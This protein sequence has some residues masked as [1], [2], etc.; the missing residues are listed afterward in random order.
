[1]RNS[2]IF[3]IY[4]YILMGMLLVFTGSCEKDVDEVKDPNPAVVSEI[5]KDVD[6]NEYHTVTIGSQVWMAENLKVTK[7]RN[8]EAIPNVTDNHQWNSFETGAYCN[9]NNDTVIGNKYGRLYNWLAVSDIRNIAP[10]GWHV[11][12]DVEWKTLESYV[13][14]FPSSSASQ[15]KDLASKTDWA[16]SNTPGTVGNDLTK[17]NATGFSALPGGCR[18]NTGYFYYIGNAGYWWRDNRKAKSMQGTDNYL[19][20]DAVGYSYNHGFSVRCIKD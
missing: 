13:A 10:V 2:H 11:A 17:N 19:V 7:Y 16:F 4:S 12:S 6:G 18:I 9:Y 3:T 1:M 20:Y 14:A 5:V 15:A 8:G